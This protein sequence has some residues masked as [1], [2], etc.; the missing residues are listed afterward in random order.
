[1]TGLDA[2]RAAADEGAWERV[3]DA[4][5]DETGLSDDAL[6][7]RAAGLYAAGALDQCLECWQRL[8]ARHAAAG[9]RD[10]AA[11]AA[12]MTAL[13]LLIDTGLMAPVRGWIARAERALGETT[14]GPAQALIATVCGYERLFSGDLESARAHSAAAVQLG[15]EHD[16]VMA[17][18][19][20]QVAQARIR[21]LDGD[22]EAG[23]RALNEAGTQLMSG[24]ADPLTTGM[25]LCE[26]VCAAQGLAMPD[27]ARHW[28]DLM[29]AWSSR[30]PI[31]SV[32]GRCRVHRA[33]LLRM[34]GPCDAAESEALAACAE[35]RPWLR[36]E[37]G[38]PLAEL[39]T[40]RLRKGDLAG[41]QAAFDTANELAWP[42]QPGLAMLRLAQGDAAAAAELIADAVA[43]PPTLP[44][45][46][47]PP[48]GDLRIAPLLEAQAEIAAANGDRRTCATAAAALARIANAFPSAGLA[49]AASL[50]QARAALLAGHAVRAR[51]L[52]SAAADG[53]SELGAQYE[54]AAARVAAG[55]ALAAM[56]NQPAAHVEW[57]VAQRLFSTYGAQPRV[58]ELASRLGARADAQ[59]PRAAAGIFRRSGQ[60]RMLGLAGACV[61]VPDLLGFRYIEQLIRHGGQ[62]V[63]AVDLVATEHPGSHVGQLGLPALDEQARRAYRQHLADIADDIAEATAMNDLARVERAQRDRDFLIAELA[64]S[65]GLGGR[66][67]QVGGDAERAR[68]SVFRTIRYAIGRAVQIEPTVGGHLRAS[69]RTGTM[70]AYEPDPLSPVAW[71][72]TSSGNAPR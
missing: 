41:A 66:I 5:P 19:I 45:K 40:I 46:E 60:L 12:A 11:R 29:A 62:E 51:Q 57:T 31:G 39:G 56:G 20:G 59:R 14:N 42:A 38:W 67:R 55:D 21:V 1:M 47:R 48:L 3:L 23:V 65:T 70:C 68:T 26:I 71:D 32:H 69:I 22:L 8:H 72:L 9:R 35:L 54:S 6:E 61:T 64:R 49:A 16:V 24:A 50:A 17:A 15:Q 13:F 52:A 28:T 27:L 53:W 63:A 37:Y 25:M 33:E 7:L 44:W 58:R 4:L 10:L 36:R 18:V 43:N 30:A 34:S 2:A